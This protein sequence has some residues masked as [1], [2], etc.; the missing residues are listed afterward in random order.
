VRGSGPIAWDSV[1]GH[2]NF[3]IELS[4]GASKLMG[5]KSHDLEENEC[6]EDNLTFSFRQC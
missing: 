5:I 6:N 3:E 4:A 1:N 2:V